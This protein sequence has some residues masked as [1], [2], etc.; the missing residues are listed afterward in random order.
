MVSVGRSVRSYV[1]AG[2]L[3]TREGSRV[4]PRESLV[5]ETTVSEQLAVD[6]QSVAAVTNKT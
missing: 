2:L 3:S 6:G 1:C 4:A 5:C